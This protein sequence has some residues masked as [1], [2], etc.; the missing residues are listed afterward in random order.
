MGSGAHSLEW[1]AHY[2]LVIL[3]MV[4]MCFSCYLINSK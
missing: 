3:A 1:D 4:T 2:V